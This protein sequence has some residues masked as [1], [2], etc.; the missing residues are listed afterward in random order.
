[1]NAPTPP[2]LLQRAIQ[3]HGAAAL[4][5]AAAL[6]RQITTL[7][8]AHA[9]AWNLLGVVAHQKGQY[10][11]ALGLI[12]RAIG[13]RADVAD[14]HANYALALTS[15]GILAQAIDSHNRA[16]ALDPRCGAA[17]GGLAKL[18]RRQ[19]RLDEAEQLLRAL[20]AARPSVAAWISLGELLALRGRHSEAHRAYQDGLRLDPNNAHAHNGLGMLLYREHRYDDALLAFRTALRHA[21]AF[22]EP[23]RN[24]PA[25][26]VA[27]GRVDEAVVACREYLSRHPQDASAASLPL[28]LAHYTSHDRAALFAEH[29]AW[30]QHYA[31]PGPPSP[32]SSGQE[33][34]DRNTDRRLRIGYVSPD[35]RQHSVAFFIEPLLQ[36]HD[37]AAVELFCY[38]DVVAVDD[39]TLRLQRRADHWRAVAGLTDDQFCAQVRADRIDILVDLAGHTA[40]NRLLAFAQ[41][42]APVQATYLGYPDTTGLRAI[43][44][45]ITD[46]VADPG[47]D[48]FHSES[49]VRLP[50][51]AWCYRPP[52]SSPHPNA[53]PAK[54]C[55]SI[56][57]GSF[58]A[59]AKLSSET[60]DLWSQALAGMPGS[61]LMLKSAALGEESTSRR[62]ADALAAR[63]IEADRLLLRGHDALIKHHLRTYHEVDIALDT[64]PY[65]GTTTTC[66][67][68]WMGVPVVCMTGDSHVSRVGASLLDAVGLGELS[69]DSPRRFVD[70]AVTLAADLSRLAKL[71]ST[72]RGTMQRSP[73]M[74]AAAL[75]RAM[76]SSYRDMWRRRVVTRSPRVG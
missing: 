31:P 72:L 27:Q 42:P 7:D 21:P 30:A 69:A 11:D 57:F 14:F 41:R 1:M 62:V 65:H 59:L 25:P 39:V 26:L 63:G 74:D 71:R 45:R 56:T 67:A 29:V 19:G 5:E 17:L 52:D 51:C 70:A 76:E 75:A 13:L 46:A 50:R 24:M 22:A 15:L 33:D 73:L 18:R 61:R 10:Q 49:L 35:F 66:D 55:G 12:G 54:E 20:T 48:V 8:P 4:D 68:L 34:E 44:Y 47:G 6:Y 28:L 3:L 36:A 43:D 16:L 38:S 9:V 2:Q 32:S 64:F 60:R 23:L 53:L 40:G 58:N 37:R